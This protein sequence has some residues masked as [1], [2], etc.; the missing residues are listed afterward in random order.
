MVDVPRKG[1]TVQLQR[2]TIFCRMALCRGRSSHIVDDDWNP[3]PLTDDGSP[4]S[5]D[6]DE[7]DKTVEGSTDVVAG[8]V[9]FEW[10]ISLTRIMSEIL[11]KF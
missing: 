3:D 1:R 4:D 7:D 2:L 8:G 10:M 6:D 9:A 11:Q 5:Q